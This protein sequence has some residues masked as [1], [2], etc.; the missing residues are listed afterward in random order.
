LA[1]RDTRRAGAEAKTSA[2]DLVLDADRAAEDAIVAK[3][4][5]EFPDDEIVSEEGGGFQ[6]QDQNLRARLGVSA[7]EL[8]SASGD[9]QNVPGQ[10]PAVHDPL[11]IREAPDLGRGGKALLDRGDGGGERGDVFEELG[12]V[13]DFFQ[14]KCRSQ[15]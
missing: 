1:R 10:V 2:T 12:D 15:S 8:G 13:H 11:T 3:L 14:S 9:D 4:R 6:G 5:A 7:I